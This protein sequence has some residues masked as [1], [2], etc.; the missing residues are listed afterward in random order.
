ME[1]SCYGMS[2][3]VVADRASEMRMNREIELG[4]N[5]PAQRRAKWMAMAK[6]DTLEPTTLRYI[7]RVLSLVVAGDASGGSGGVVGRRGMIDKLTE[8]GLFV[9]YAA[10]SL[11]AI[12]MQHRLT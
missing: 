7:C 3:W 10:R 1:Q 5:C 8:R 4:R 12:A 9:C 6:I 2:R 11:N